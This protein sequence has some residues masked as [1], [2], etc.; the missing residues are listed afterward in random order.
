MRI[1]IIRCVL[2]LLLFCTFVVIFNFSSEDS[3]KSG[4]TSQRVTEAI[5]KNIESIQ[6][7]DNVKKA[8]VL[9]KIESVI[10]KIAHFSIYG[11]VGVLLMALLSTYNITDKNKIIFTIVLGAIYASSDEFHQSFIPGRSGEVRDVMLDTLG[12][13]VGGLIVLAIIKL[14]EKIKLKNSEINN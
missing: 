9:D 2:V 4:S 3:E 14:I 1:N 13:A 8:K 7:L 10:R 12:V 6:K 5:T 11:L